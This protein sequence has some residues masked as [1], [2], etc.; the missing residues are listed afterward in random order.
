M[1]SHSNYGRV[2]NDILRYWRCGEMTSLRDESL[3]KLLSV[4]VRF[5]RFHEYWLSST[6][7]SLSRLVR[8]LKLVP[9]TNARCCGANYLHLA[10]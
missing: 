1:R 6:L 2:M 7:Q 8:L 9:R 5:S 3:G 4:C 10:V